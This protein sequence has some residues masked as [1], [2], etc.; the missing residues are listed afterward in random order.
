MTRTV[1]MLAR[2]ELR[3]RVASTLLIAIVVTCAGALALACFAAA[4]RTASVHE[5]YERAT[6]TADASFSSDP[7]CGERPCTVEDFE[8]VDGVA[9]VARSVRL[10]AIPEAPDGSLVLE[11]DG[12]A[13]LA[14]GG[15][16]AWAIDR[17][18]V[19]EGRLPTTD[20]GDEVFVNTT[21]AR[22]N[23]VGPGDL[24]RLRAFTFDEIGAL[25]ANPDPQTTAGRSVALRVVGTGLV[26][27][28]LEQG[29]LILG[30]EPV[31]E[32]FTP[33]GATFSIELD[34][35]RT[36]ASAFYAAAKDRWDLDPEVGTET[37]HDR[38]QRSIRPYLSALGAYAAFAALVGA[39]VI[40]QSFARQTRASA[41][42]HRVLRAIGVTRRQ[43][44]YAGAMGAALPALGGAFAA[45]LVAWLASGQ[46]PVGPARAFEPEP[47]LSF[48]AVVLVLGTMA[49]ALLAL[50][51]A[52]GGVLL[53]SRPSRARAARAELGLTRSLPVAIATAVRFAR[54]RQ[55]SGGSAPTRTTVVGLATMS[56]VVA[57]V[58]TFA[59]GL[60][61][62]VD[63]PRLY[64]WNHDASIF[65]GYQAESPDVLQAAA[66]TVGPQLEGEPVVSGVTAFAGTEVTLLGTTVTGVGASGAG[67]AFTVVAGHPPS[68]PN[69]MVIGPRTARR[70]GAAV[71]D[72][73]EITAGASRAVYTVVGK[74]VL[75]DT[76]GDGAA[77]TL[78]GLRR[79][80][81]E[82]VVSSL[83][84]RFRSTA[85]DAERRAAAE[86]AA[87]TL[88]SFVPDATFEEPVPP[89]DATELLAI[90]ALP[91]ALGATLGLASLVT[92]VHTLLLALRSRRRDL[93]TLRA[94]GYGRG[95]VW[96]TVL[97]QAMLVLGLALV[98]GLPLGVAAGRW[99]WSVWA[100]GIGVVDTAVT[101]TA[102]L[103]MVVPLALL[104]AALFA[105]GPARSASRQPV[106]AALRAE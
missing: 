38:A 84:V 94:C 73:V 2:R 68:A 39:L 86:R 61:R 33:L 19:K 25:I 45:G 31:G 101:P 35:G 87:R 11:D 6:N 90:D 24:V 97:S 44:W 1:V 12:S 65:L 66:D 40:A 51:A 78:D 62:L 50:L 53:G 81:P 48:D 79:V 28:D 27:P 69:E 99:L 26:G 59:A 37:P 83:G 54:P 29:G 64:G 13:F 8:A 103:A 89:S 14:L 21:Y 74:A 34:D 93:A 72:E 36:G 49:W 95:Q 22:R 91:W 60:D 80:A 9:R 52:V 4:R 16:A 82:V 104:A 100:R 58:V 105:I 41:D 75:A 57:L 76:T 3:R 55:A 85:T 7:Q 30:A 23:G 77:F 43:L 42:R 102:F 10:L 17:P 5:R 46:A 96:A 92:L 88:S 71:G 70:T 56:L 63:T 47:G 15:G 67:G 32:A 98:V 106:A 20:A 18:L